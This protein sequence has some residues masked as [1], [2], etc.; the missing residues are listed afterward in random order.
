MAMAVSEN[1]TGEAARHM[2]RQRTALAKIA[3][4]AL[5]AMT[6]ALAANCAQDQTARRST[7]KEI[8]AFSHPK[9]GTASQRVVAD[10]QDVPKG[11]GRDLVGKPYSIAGKRYA[12]YEKPAGYTQVGSA[13]WYGEAFHGRRTANGE[14]YDRHGVSAAHPTMPLPSYARVTNALN[15]RSII[16]RVNDRGPYHGGRIMDLSQKTADALSF[17]HLG[18][19]RVK[20]EYLGRASLRGS[21]DSKLIATLR[22]DG[23]PASLPGAALVQVA[24]ADAPVVTRASSS[25][26]ARSVDIDGDG[27]PDNLQQPAQAAVA[28]PAPVQP[29]RA[30]P[31]ETRLPDNALALAPVQGGQPVAFA[32]RPPERPYDLATIPNA[33]TQVSTAVPG[34]TIQ[35]APTRPVV[36]SLF[37]APERAPKVAFAKGNPMTTLTAQRFE[38]LA[39]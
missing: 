12:P 22:T 31:A 14:I 8:G 19:A 9:Y 24:S 21:D 18:T 34:A 15:G 26:I 10:G 1:A 33:G 27:I 30:A 29:V 5:V 23:S 11:G 35:R 17:R 4:V 7:S 16:V 3:R 36:A 6:G 37:Y 32:P 28:A 39:R 2:G 13:S 20:V 25:Q 38:P